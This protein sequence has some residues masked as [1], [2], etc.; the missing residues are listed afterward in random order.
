MRFYTNI[1]RI[2][3]SICYRGYKDGIR[4]QFRDSF[5]PVM[6]LTSRKTDCEWRTL[7]GR[8]VEPMVFD[9][10]S[11]AT[12]FAK[13]YENVDSLEAHG[14]TNFA[15]QY[16]QKNY[17]KDIQYDS[18]VIKIANIDIEVASDD[19]FPE[20]ERADAEV[21]S[22]CLK[23][24]GIKTVY[25]WALEEKYEPSKTELDINPE[26]IIF[27]KC[28][29]ELD[30][31]LK[32][33]QFW[34]HRDTCPDVV[35]GWNVRMFDLPY[36]INRTN[37]LIGVDTSKKMSP[38][39]MVREKQVS[40]QGRTQQ[41]YD[42]VG[43]E[44]LDYWDLFQK[45]GVYSYGVQESYKLDHISNVVLGEKK[46]SY[47][48]HGNLYTL[49]KEDYQKFIDY[50]IKDVLLVERIDEKMG[51]I[52]LAMTIAYKGGCNYQEAFGTTQLWDTYIY[53]E[54]CSRKIVVPP[55]MDHGKVDFGGGF[56]KTPQI[57]R[58]SWVVSFDLNSLYPHLIMQ[59]N[60]SPETIVSTRTSGVTVD[61]CLDKTR[62]DSKSP[63]D[64]IAANGVHFSKDERGVL[65]SI[66]DGLY[67]E[68]KQIKKN[69]LGAQSQVEKGV[70]GAEKEITKLDTQ[71]MAIKIMMNSLYGALGN[72]WFR[73]YDIRMAEAITMSGQLSIRWAEKAVNQYM[74]KIVGTEDFDYV[75]AID[76]DSVYVNFG[77]L[78]EKM[79]LT[80][81][82]K[83]VQV[84]SQIGEDKFEPLFDKSYADLAN[85]M[86]AY[87]NKMVMG[88]EAIADA[89]IWTAKKR[90][91]LNV[92]NNEG[93]QYAKPKL[94][95][96]GIEAVKSSTPASCRDA[97]KGLFKVMITGTEKQTQDAIQLFKTH[98][99]SLAPHEV[100]F[101]RGV[102]DIG[103]WRDRNT[104]YKKGC[105]IHV[106]GSLL[107]NKLLLDNGLEKRY[108]TIK[109]GEK[110]KFLYLDKKNPMKENV[111]AF[112]DFLPKE[113][114]LHKYIDYDTQF[115]KAFLAVVRP[116]LEAIGWTEEEVIS[117]EDFFG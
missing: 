33:I 89:G 76:T 63:T 6:Y 20:P 60:M 67:S 2:G 78:V 36:L 31:L 69:M 87:A 66:I 4:E 68:R 18:S 86:N 85:Y 96:M 40:L 3:N 103:K 11:E 75:I 70:A 113:F 105:P 94:K 93:V 22:I 45:F 90:Y 72:R 81:T 14:N 49:Y 110:I 37:R 30:L 61:N 97:L 8:C 1:S 71:Q 17:P 91:I 57:G 48:E 111:I 55:K 24:F 64:C 23:Y 79:G 114:G 99:K 15:A 80:D 51:L 62:P 73:Y 46:L 35:T 26:D 38:W 92:H 21:Q 54:L 102:S 25:I 42:I 83:T 5:N 53:R 44:Q 50:N 65:P 117:L 43:I 7:D 10:M 106:R 47:E 29:G 98:F 108:N 116:V 74:N 9:S 41:V 28:D 112:Y 77:P 13:R 58:H 19:G 52:D 107:Y 32:F 59:F 12:D 16:I 82:D 104:V 88:R 27:I 39:N 84:L 95:I 34:N 101:P 109:D 56:V 100:A 115:E